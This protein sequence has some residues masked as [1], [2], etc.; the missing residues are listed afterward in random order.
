MSFL[1]MHQ[2][3]GFVDG[4]VAQ[5]PMFVTLSSGFQQ[6]NPGYATWLCLDHLTRAWLFTT[7]SKVLLTEVRDLPHCFSVWHQLEA[8]FNMA[9][10]ARAM[11][12]KRMLMNLDKC[13]SQ[14]MEDFLRGV[15]SIADSLASIQSFVLDL[16]LVQYTLNALGPDYDGNVDTLTY[17][18]GTLTFNDVCTKLLFYE[19]CVKFLKHRN[20]GS[21]THAA[22]RRF[23]YF[24]I[25]FISGWF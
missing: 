17:V 2:L 8:R 14:S 5:P 24:C 20:S 19:Q 23:V 6:P 12:L 13:E 1:I 18:P 22:F 7:I 4:L 3:H 21:L 10:L 16:D 11:D 25:R 9:S 15:K